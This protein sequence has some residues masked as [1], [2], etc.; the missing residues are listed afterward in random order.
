MYHFYGHLTLFLLIAFSICSCNKE[1]KN[2]ALVTFDVKFEELKN[3]QGIC[4]NNEVEEVYF[5]KAK[6]NPQV[7]FYDLEG[8]L[9]DSL[10][11]QQV[12]D[13]IGRIGRFTVISKDTM[14]AISY[15]SHQMVGVKRDGSFIFRINLDSLS[16]PFDDNKYCFW[17]SFT[18]SPINIGDGII[19][20]LA[21]NGKHRNEYQGTTDLDYYKNSVL[22]RMHSPLIAK[23]EDIYSVSPQIK[24]GLKDYYYDKSSGLTCY[25]TLVPNYAILNNKLFSILAND[26]NIYE[27]DANTLNI[28]D[29]IPVIPQKYVIPSGVKL[30][31][32]PDFTED[33]ASEQ[34]LMDKCHITNMLYNDKNKQYYIFLKTGKDMSVVDEL[35]YSFMLYVYDENFVKKNQY[36]FNS[37]DYNPKSAMMTSKGIMI[38][39]ISKQ[40]DYGKK[41][42]E[43]MDL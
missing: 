29:T 12:E 41:T 21:Y 10:S 34:E 24:Y 3:Y 31:D 1:K 36:S 15:Q 14:I 4:K 16:A 30:K 8:N 22:N 9:R 2:P 17:G 11:L 18:P 20:N 32:E 37:D 43:F 19:V 38:E 26:R 28:I 5:F 39:K 7:K 6:F 25:G 40:Q 33:M 35:G 42:F 27:L 13:S 23:I